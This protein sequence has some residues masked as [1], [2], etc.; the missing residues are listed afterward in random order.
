MA[1]Q[2]S[3]Q[4]KLDIHGSFKLGPNPQ[5]S[6]R[7]D[8]SITNA[9]DP[10]RLNPNKCFYLKGFLGTG[11]KALFLNET[12]A[13]KCVKTSP[14]D[15]KLV[16]DFSEKDQDEFSLKI[17]SFKSFQTNQTV[18]ISLSQV[19]SKT[20][21]G[22][23]AVLQ[24]TTDFGDGSLELTVPKTIDA[25]GIIY[26]YSDPPDGVQNLP[27]DSVTLKWRTYKLTNRE[28][29]QAG[30]GD[31]LPCEFE[32]DEGATTIPSVTADANFRLKGYDGSK[33]IEREL[34]VNVLRSGW[35]DTKHIMQEGDPGY[36]TSLDEGDFNALEQVGNRYE[37]EPTLLLNAND[38]WLYAIFRYRFQ[39]K[40]HA[41]IYRTT[42]PFGGWRLVDAQVPGEVS[43]SPGVYYQNHIWLI[44]G[45]Q[46]DQQRRS[47]SVWRLNPSHNQ[48][49]R[50]W[51]Q[52]ADAKWP[53]RMGHAL[54]VFENK[55][56]VIGGRDDGGNALNDVWWTC[57]NEQGDSLK[58]WTEL[59]EAPDGSKTSWRARCLVNPEVFDDR[60]WLYG[61]ALEPSSAEL[62]DDLFTIR[63]DADMNYYIFEAKKITDVVAGSESRKPIASCLQV[64]GGKLH[65]FGKFRTTAESDGSRFDEPIGY[66]LSDPETGTWERF[67]S[68]GLGTWGTHTTFSYQALNFK[69]RMLVAKALPASYRKPNPIL[70]VYIP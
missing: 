50:K 5:P 9:G 45:S 55:I 12:D 61:G 47:K 41:L 3:I 31:P 23:A 40:E 27:G 29:T 64:L 26:F 17:F 21:P 57:I 18:K 49:V 69:D 58:T 1:E 37:L 36:P 24:F 42:N 60:I 48:D 30:I 20:D 34:S 56:W 2:S 8:L 39:E 22:G 25:P 67:P 68:D 35:Y 66:R 11:A 13:Q 10:V 7:L 28:L 63:P 32:N 15:W 43:T 6:N 4:A 46:I 16:W 65:L 53:A 52:C 51:E 70:K 54:V 59:K 14:K 44:G 38:Q 19:I 62:F 33:P